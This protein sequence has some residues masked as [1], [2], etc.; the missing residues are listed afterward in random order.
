M[1]TE[2]T[3]GSVTSNDGTTIGYHQLGAGPGL[4][5][6]HGTM[7]SAQ[8]HIQLA[9]ALADTF[10]VYLPDRR[11]RGLSDPYRD[12]Y[13]VDDDIEDMHALLAGTGAHQ[14]FGISAGAI[15][16][17]QAALMLPAIRKVAIFEPPLFPDRSEPAAT[18]ARFDREMAEGRVAAALV[19]AMKGARMGPPVFHLLPRWLLERLTTMGMARDGSMHS[20]APTLHYDCELIVDMS[21]PLD[22]FAA[23]HT[24]VLL[25]GGSKSPA[26]L[27][28]TLATLA[29]VLPNATRVELA[30]L[31]HE[32]TGNADRGGKPERVAREL[33]RFFA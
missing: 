15:I 2:S 12:P 18:L 8:S 5:L 4:V 14:V 1:L 25:L 7:E 13:R 27:K 3:T 9:E 21:G 16:C 30:G 24:E 6:L 29:A 32:A 33:R 31:S 19:T 11:G 26:Y 22:R 17:L 23:L 20:L 10:T 28:R